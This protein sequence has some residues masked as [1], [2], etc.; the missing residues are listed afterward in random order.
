MLVRFR[1]EALLPEQGC[2][3]WCRINRRGRPWELFI[4]AVTVWCRL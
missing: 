2:L 4:P 1:C 3:I